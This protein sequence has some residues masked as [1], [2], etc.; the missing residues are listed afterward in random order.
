MCLSKKKKLLRKCPSLQLGWCL[1]DLHLK[2]LKIV[3]C[4][5]L[6][7]RWMKQESKRKW[8]TSDSDDVLGTGAT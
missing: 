6:H 4:P 3:L 2:H 7:F 8:L 1:G 5:Q